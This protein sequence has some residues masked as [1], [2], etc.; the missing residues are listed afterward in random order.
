[1]NSRL[2]SDSSPHENLNPKPINKMTL[3]IVFAIALAHCLND[4]IQAS[5]PAIYP[6]LKANFALSFTQI[7]LI[8]LVYQITASLLQ[9]W[10]GFY[11]DKYPR[12][13]LLP[14]GMSITLIGICVLAFSVS[15][16]MLLV[17]AALIGVGSSTFP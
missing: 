16:T 2:Q 14:I 9:P 12:P 3:H 7:G 6:L 15:F 1:M 10:V 4:L 11:T 5:L 13:Y 8:S 17:A